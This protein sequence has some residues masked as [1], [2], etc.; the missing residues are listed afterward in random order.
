MSK[1]RDQKKQI[2]K[3]LADPKI[4]EILNENKLLVQGAN[5]AYGQASKERIAKYMEKVDAVLHPK[6]KPAPRDTFFDDFPALPQIEL[7]P[8]PPKN[9]SEKTKAIKSYGGHKDDFKQETYDDMRKD[10][11]RVNNITE[12]KYGNR[13]IAVES[14]ATFTAW[15]TVTITY[16]RKDSNETREYTTIENK[17]LDAKLRK[18]KNVNVY[19]QMLD[20]VKHDLEMVYQNDGYMKELLAITDVN[21]IPRQ[22]VDIRNV[23][24]REEV[25]QVFGYQLIGVKNEEAFKQYFKNN[26]TCVID[27][28]LFELCQTKFHKRYQDRK[29]LEQWFGSRYRGCLKTGIT[30]KMITDF[31]K[32]LGD[33]SVH[34][35]DMLGQKMDKHKYVAEDSKVYFTFIIN[36]N[37]VYPLMGHFKTMASRSR[38]YIFENMNGEIDYSDHEYCD[39][40]D[41]DDLIKGTFGKAKV[42]LIN[43]KDLKVLACHVICATRVMVTTLKFQCDNVH[44]FVH[45]VSKQIY[46]CASDYQLRKDTCDQMRKELGSDI[47]T[48]RN[49]SFADLAQNYYNIKYG[50]LVP[51]SYSNEFIDA[52]QH[53]SVKPYIA[54]N[55]GDD[56]IDHDG[57]VSFDFHRCY[58]SC[59]IE[60]AYDFAVF[61]T[62][63]PEE[64]FNPAD[65]IEVGRYYVDVDVEIGQDVEE[66]DDE[67][68]DDVKK[69]VPHMKIVKG[70]MPHNLVDCLLKA[71]HITKDDIKFKQV[72]SGYM[73]HDIFA[74]FSTHLYTNY[75]AS[76]YLINSFYGSL[77][78]FMNKQS[79]AG[80]TDSLENAQAI[81]CEEESKGKIVKVVPLG[82][83]YF[84]RSYAEQ[85]LT[86]GHVPIYEHIVSA[87]LIKLIEMYKAVV[88]PYTKVYG[89]TVDSIKVSNPKCEIVSGPKEIGKFY[90]DNKTTV[91]G[92][93]FS[94]LACDNYVQKP[95]AWRAIDE[96][97]ENVIDGSC[98]VTAMPGAGKTHLMSVAYKKCIEN[99]EK[100]IAFT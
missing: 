67:T 69:F 22:S 56:E 89:F 76:K 6:P 36:N 23:P 63:D 55:V 18:G 90:L 13:E 34:P 98:L 15:F 41:N 79:V 45:P 53:S 57:I 92:R 93:H 71:K 74:D 96:K 99:G 44:A 77:G 17:L 84:V 2:A 64:V 28:I 70:W 87:G 80:F 21:V 39:Q 33:V 51:S 4:S 43:H 59:G 31:A 30:L 78:R 46:V 68:G 49:Q 50:M 73:K 11:E 5:L 20:S 24:N 86:S 14:V 7:Q 27:Y 35:V 29:A 48:F 25:D 60:N 61:N 82:N 52:W 97:V 37:H 19:K 58:T 66:Y 62:L 8:A 9:K 16:K 100:I 85:V 42:V 75:P 40:W 38:G 91:R 81:R 94:E 72:A 54:S 12:R 47:F 3:L 95:K 1:L 32:E 10:L 88:G 65:K 83:I 26:G